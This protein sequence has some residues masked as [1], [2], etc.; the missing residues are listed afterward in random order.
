MSGTAENTYFGSVEVIGIKLVSINSYE[1]STKHGKRNENKGFRLKIKK[2]KKN[3]TKY[4][5]NTPEEV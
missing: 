5:D 1:L 3:I 2:N 4:E